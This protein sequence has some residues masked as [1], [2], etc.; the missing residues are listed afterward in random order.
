M[1]MVPSSSVLLGGSEGFT[2]CGTSSGCSGSWEGTWLGSSG[3]PDG[4]LGGTPVPGC[5]VVA[6]AGSSDGGAGMVGAG[7]A[8]G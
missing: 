3:F 1:Y 8:G 5:K 4:S 6:P 7:L 2:C